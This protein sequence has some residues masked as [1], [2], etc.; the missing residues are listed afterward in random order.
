VKA[1]E[2]VAFLHLDSR[3]GEGPD[4]AKAHV[5]RGF[6]TFILTNAAGDPIDR[7]VGYRNAETWLTSFGAAVADPTTLDQKKARFEA[8]PTAKDAA[9][10][11]RVSAGRGVSSEA[12]DYYRRALELDPA[13]A[14]QQPILDATAALYR[15]GE[16]DVALADVKAAA[17]AAL[18]S[19]HATADSKVSLAFGMRRVA[20]HAKDMKLIA[21]YVDAALEATKGSTELADTRK[22]L[23]VEQALHVAGDKEKALRLKRQGMPA[24]WLKDAGQLNA[25]A[26]WCFENQVGLAE[27]EELA[28]KAVSL[29]E[30]GTEKAMI[31][32]TVAEI[33]NLRGSC[34]DAV[35]LIKWAMR[36]DPENET[37][38]KQ[39]ER[40]EKALASTT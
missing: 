6:P 3:T 36:E 40:F 10:L 19:A 23:L 17:D 27:A 5:V 8:A 39:L 7:W 26:W 25:Y 16:R 4:L 33:C 1:L 35:S 32:D 20:E 15:K 29:A 2:T 24:G 31:L 18:T 21:P 28:R 38:P 13:G 30:P 11:G 34:S 22:H 9:T 37:Y 14:Y 12:L